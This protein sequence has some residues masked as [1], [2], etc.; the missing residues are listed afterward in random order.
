MKEYQA[1]YREKRRNMATDT[2]SGKAEDKQLKVAERKKKMK[3]YQVQYRVKAK[4]K[5]EEK[6]LKQNKY[7]NN[8]KKIMRG[9]T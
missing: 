1:E 8:Y 3:E 2:K 5:K 6:L 7:Q 4:A 9:G